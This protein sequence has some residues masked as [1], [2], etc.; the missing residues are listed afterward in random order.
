[1]RL[2]AED[3]A[4]QLAGGHQGP[5]AVGSVFVE[6]RNQGTVKPLQQEVCGERGIGHVELLRPDVTLDKVLHQLAELMHSLGLAHHPHET[7]RLA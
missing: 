4:R 3:L 5:V 1:M 2:A 7:K 6:Y